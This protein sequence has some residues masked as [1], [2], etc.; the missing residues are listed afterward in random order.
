M[1][2]SYSSL[3]HETDFRH[4][5]GTD[6]PGVEDFGF[7][8]PPPELLPSI[9]SDVRTDAALPGGEDFGF[10]DYLPL[11]SQESGMGAAPSSESHDFRMDD[12]LPPPTLHSTRIS[13][14][15]LHGTGGDD[16]FGMDD[17]MPPDAARKDEEFGMNIP[18]PSDPQGR[19]WSW[20]NRAP[21]PRDTGPSL[22]LPD[23]P[24]LQQDRERD[25]EY[26][27]QA[28]SLRAEA[29]RIRQL[30]SELRQLIKCAAWSVYGKGLSRYRHQYEIRDTHET[31]TLSWVC[32][33]MVQ[34]G[35]HRRHRRNIITSPT[36][37]QCY[38]TDT[39]PQGHDTDMMPPGYNINTAPR[40]GS[41]T[42]T[43]P[44]GY[45]GAAVR[46]C[47]NE[48]PG[49]EAWLLE[50]G[51]QAAKLRLSPPATHTETR[52][53]MEIL[54]STGLIRY[55]ETNE[56]A[57]PCSFTLGCIGK[58]KTGG[59]G[60]EPAKVLVRGLPLPDRYTI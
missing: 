58:D 18:L 29:N 40:C 55:R 33:Y 41:D 37:P 32:Q 24:E 5:Q 56:E 60:F 28:A 42:D 3:P 15:P 6:Q 10:D 34:A 54:E 44:R 53:P 49:V 25:R 11:Q 22:Q 27:A 1:A 4:K 46:P 36:L 26:R 13:P 38:N 17:P 7:D 39:A 52:S 14:A 30:Y 2:Q 8:T 48:Q 43:V 57:L 35:S 59:S 50:L 12:P 16:D 21:P 45:D 23:T 19:V 9:P 20:G 51:A 31:S 47:R